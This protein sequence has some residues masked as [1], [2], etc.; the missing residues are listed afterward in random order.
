MS[1]PIHVDAY[2]C[3]KANERGRANSNSTNRC[4][5]SPQYSISGANCQRPI[6]KSRAW[7]ARPTCSV[8]MKKQMSGHCRVVLTVMSCW[9]VLAD[10]I[11]EFVALHRRSITTD[12]HQASSFMLRDAKQQK[13]VTPQS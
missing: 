9:P 10:T 13:L 11:S 12:H 5:R 3:Y 2:S 1:L 6:S 4:M 7:K 8:T